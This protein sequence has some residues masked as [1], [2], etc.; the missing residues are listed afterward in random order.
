MAPTGAGFLQCGLF[1]GV[2]LSCV[3]YIG[4]LG[5]LDDITG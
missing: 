1:V 3:V 5:G 4:G 2:V